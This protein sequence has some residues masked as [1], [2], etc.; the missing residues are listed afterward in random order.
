MVCFFKFQYCRIANVR[1]ALG[2]NSLHPA[3]SMCVHRTPYT[4]NDKLELR[5]RD[6]SSNDNAKNKRRAHTS[7]SEDCFSFSQRSKRDLV[8]ISCAQLEIQ[9]N[10]GMQIKSQCEDAEKK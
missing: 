8:L 5:N 10:S 7:I 3:V 1:T 4:F 6:Y 2:F 9:L